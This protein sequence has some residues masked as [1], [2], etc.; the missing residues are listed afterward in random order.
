MARIGMMSIA[1]AVA[2]AGCVAGGEYRTGR[3][4]IERPTQ[5]YECSELAGRGGSIWVGTFN[6]R[7]EVD[8]I[9]QRE[10]LFTRACFTDETNC[11]NWLYNLLSEY[12]E[13][14]WTSECRRAVPR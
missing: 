5:P 10:L 13:Q 2:V 4:F 14:V 12:K 3:S 9:A 8:Y 6:G 11:R 7:R 1:A